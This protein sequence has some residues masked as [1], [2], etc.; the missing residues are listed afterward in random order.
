MVVIALKREPLVDSLFLQ[1]KQFRERAHRRDLAK[2]NA[3]KQATQ[4]M[5][6]VQALTRTIT[7]QLKQA[8]FYIHSTTV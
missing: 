3:Y 6:W 8:N 7:E 5:P 4:S 1:T 2:T